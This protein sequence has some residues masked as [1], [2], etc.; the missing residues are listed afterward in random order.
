MK[1]FTCW[2]L[3]WLFNEGL[4]PFPSYFNIAKNF[5]FDPSLIFYFCVLA[6][7]FLDRSRHSE[8]LGQ[9]KVEG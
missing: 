1:L 9:K 2:A 8:S 7:S 4:N 6:L 3:L 5:P